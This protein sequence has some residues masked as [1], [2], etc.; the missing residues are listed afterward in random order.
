MSA[1]YSFNIIDFEINVICILFASICNINY[2]RYFEGWVK[3]RHVFFSDSI[4]KCPLEVEGDLD[5][6]VF[7]VHAVAFEE[8]QTFGSHVVVH[9]G[10]IQIYAFVKHIQF[11]SFPKLNRKIC[12]EGGGNIVLHK[13]LIH[14]IKMGE[15]EGLGQTVLEDLHGHIEEVLFVLHTVVGIMGQLHQTL[16]LLSALGQL[17]GAVSLEV[18]LVVFEEHVVFIEVHLDSISLVQEEPPL[19]L[20]L[21]VGA[22]EVEVVVDGVR[23]KGFVSEE[24]LVKDL[25]DLVLISLFEVLGKRV[26]KVI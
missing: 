10:R 18:E 17:V 3:S 25:V 7:E 4:F 19:V 9:I 11:V 16:P 1:F 13:G 26:F 8:A 14:D 5:H 20:G 21:D 6:V 15:L 2:E 24:S 22:E 23:V 12:V